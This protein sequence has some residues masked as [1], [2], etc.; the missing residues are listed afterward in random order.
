M[1][2][3]IRAS[4]ATG[5]GRALLFG[6]RLCGLSPRIGR[7]CSL[8]APPAPLPTD[9]TKPSPAIAKAAS[10]R[11]EAQRA[12]QRERIHGDNLGLDA[13]Q[14]V[15]GAAIHAAGRPCALVG[16]DAGSPAK[17]VSIRRRRVFARLA[18]RTRGFGASAALRFR[19][20][21]AFRRQWIQMPE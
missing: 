8:P 14:L 17:L 15:A 20:N 13:G 1:Q 2:S 4:A 18:D 9:L 7:R 11:D 6:A 3:D 5:F 21:T 12:H 16:V 10:L 19:A